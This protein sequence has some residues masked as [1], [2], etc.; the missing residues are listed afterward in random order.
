TMTLLKEPRK[1]VALLVLALSLAGTWVGV[2]ALDRYDS[3]TLTSTP[4][5]GG[6]PAFANTALAKWTPS[7]EPNSPE[8]EA[9]ENPLAGTAVASLSATKER[10]LFSSSRRPPAPAA[11]PAQPLPMPVSEPRRPALSLV[12]VVVGEGEAFAIFLEEK[13]K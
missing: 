10:P 8:R 2:Q 13:T 6:S 12:G 5:R 1:R 11:A 4:E 7:A 3:T 9:S